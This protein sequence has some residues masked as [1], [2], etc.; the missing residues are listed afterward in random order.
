[1]GALCREAGIPF[2]LIT[3]GSDTHQYLADP[4][5][6]GKIV[7][8][9]TA[10]EALICRS[11]DLRNRLET[12]GV[13]RE[14]LH[15]IYNGIDPDVFCPRD[16]MDS[17]RALSLDVEPPILLFVGNLLPIKNPLFLIRAHAKLNSLRTGAGLP[18][19]RLY[20]IGEG[21]LKDKMLRE[22][23]ILGTSTEVKFLGRRNS[24][25]VAIWMNAA[26]LFCLSSLNEGFPNVLLEAMACGLPVVSTDVG[27]IRER[28]SSHSLG[29]LVPSGNLESYTA[30]IHEAL[31]T[32]RRND[33]GIRIDWMEAAAAHHGV[34]SVAAMGKEERDPAKTCCPA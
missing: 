20:L 21:P 1:M 27:G 33:G 14:K 4:I 3:Q 34:F 15:L 26:D 9:A 11:G 17:R 13:P 24:R 8:A 29:W 19:A 31:L 5:R 25:E 7:S 6:R 2:V 16:R 32:S 22:S 30:A 23:T 12:A 18:K 10:C 28:I